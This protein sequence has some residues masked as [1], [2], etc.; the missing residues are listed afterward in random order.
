MY[1][2]E[3]VINV[4][5]KS[6]D[7][8]DTCKNWLKQTKRRIETSAVRAKKIEQSMKMQDL[9]CNDD[10]DEEEGEK[11]AE[12]LNDEKENDAKDYENESDLSLFRK[13]IKTAT[14]KA[15]PRNNIIVIDLTCY[16]N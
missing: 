8:D 11:E 5:Y 3:E 16:F 12:K 1:A 13:A 4:T 2:L 14:K 15:T 7:A 9:Q 10:E 6:K